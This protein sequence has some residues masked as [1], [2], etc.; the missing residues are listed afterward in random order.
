MR[1]S[2]IKFSFNP[3]RKSQLSPSINRKNSSLKALKPS[4]AKYKEPKAINSVI[5]KLYTL[6]I[7]IFGLK[8]S[9]ND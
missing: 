3:S 5:N 8:K 7:N 6:V 2:M 4:N 9:L 1:K